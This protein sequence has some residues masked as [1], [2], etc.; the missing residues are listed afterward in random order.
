M[1]RWIMSSALALGLSVGCSALPSSSSDAVDSEVA[2]SV[3]SGAINTSSGSA[4]GYNDIRLQE[5]RSR[6]A[7]LVDD[8]KPIS[9]AHA[10]TWMCTGDI[11]SP[12]FSGAPA[13]PYTF[14]PVSCTIAWRNGKT[15]SSTWSSAFTLSYGASCDTHHAFIENQVGGCTLTRTTA[16]G[17]NTRTVTG[18]EGNSYAVSHDTNGA[19]TGWDASVQPAPSNSGVILTCA[20]GGCVSGL[21]VAISGSHLVGTLTPAGGAPLTWWNHTVSTGASG[22]TVTGAGTARVLDGSV[23]VQ[24][25]LAKYT[26]TTKF[27][28]V[29]YGDA[30]CCFPTSGSVSTTFDTGPNAGKSESLQFSSVCGEATLTT[31]SGATR[32]LVLQHCL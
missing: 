24:H 14:T 3:V 25:N 12:T 17:G 32:S 2:T 30:T 13:D 21:N 11:L 31:A 23:T 10:A 15:S 28:S 20:A 16:M 8:L 18:P 29:H 27:N 26:A 19:G 7:R 6:W 5:T 4:I 1:N 22:L 9:T